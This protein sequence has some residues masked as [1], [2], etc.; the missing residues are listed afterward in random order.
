MSRLDALQWFFIKLQVLAIFD[1]NVISAAVPD[2]SHADRPR[3]PL[4]TSNHLNITI[5]NTKYLKK[6][7]KHC[8]CFLIWTLT[9]WECPY[10]FSTCSSYSLPRISGWSRFAGTPDTPFSRQI[11]RLISSRSGTLHS[12]YTKSLILIDGIFRFSS[13]RKNSL[14]TSWLDLILIGIFQVERK[15]PSHYRSEKR[16]WSLISAI[17]VSDISVGK[18]CA[19]S[20]SFKWTELTF[21][22]VFILF[23]LD[24]RDD[25]HMI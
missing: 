9:S 4:I 1:M 7:K 10:I 14:I 5:Y 3:F 25:F 24:Q 19:R 11:Y 6:D 21:P 8:W 12:I 23:F 20:P 16:I 15:E 2:R 17:N 18:I 22:G 13:Y